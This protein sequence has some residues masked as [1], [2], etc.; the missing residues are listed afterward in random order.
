MNKITPT[1]IGIIGVIVALTLV[2]VFAVA[3]LRPDASA[4]LINMLLSAGG[5]ITIAAGLI[6]SNNKTSEQI[7][8][9]KENV[10]EVKAQ[11]NGNLNRRDEEIRRL[12]DMRLDE[13]RQAE[14][15]G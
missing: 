12:T 15:R 10:A 8:E 14:P 2:G 6:I 7:E 3:L 11:T 13:A 5:F 4:V 9:V 1:A